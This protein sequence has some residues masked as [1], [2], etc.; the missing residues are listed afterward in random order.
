MSELC[1]VL[2]TSKREVCQDVLVLFLANPMR[3]R[4][5]DTFTTPTKMERALSAIWGPDII[6]DVFK[7]WVQGM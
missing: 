5:L 3:M 7:R 6:E 2:Y 1:S 4:S